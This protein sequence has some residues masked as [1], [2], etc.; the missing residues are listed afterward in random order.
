MTSGPS[1][2]DEAGGPG[3]LRYTRREVS[4]VTWAIRE[5]GEPATLEEILI[6]VSQAEACSPE[7]QARIG[8]CLRDGGARLTS[9]TPVSFFSIA[10]LNGRPAWRFTRVYRTLQREHGL[11]PRFRGEA[12]SETRS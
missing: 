7:L 5:I 4:L 12:T 2:P 11:A 9:P 1:D 8:A 3:A 10:R 6:L